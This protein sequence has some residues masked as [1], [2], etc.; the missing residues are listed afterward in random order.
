M[1][2]PPSSL[3]LTSVP[4]A[5]AMD[6]K[7]DA[8]C[9]S[10]QP[11]ARTRYSLVH[12]ESNATIRFAAGFKP[13]EALAQLTKDGLAY[14]LKVSLGDASSDGT[15]AS[16]LLGLAVTESHQGKCHP[17]DP[18]AQSDHSV[19]LHMHLLHRGGHFPCSFGILQAR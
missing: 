19:P 2:S 11:E 8:I 6:S 7:I 15:V 16:S 14:F 17:F 4:Q 10:V 5:M 9:R 1:A 13:V 18:H 12:G 3:L